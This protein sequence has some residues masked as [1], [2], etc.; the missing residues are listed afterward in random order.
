MFTLVALNL[1]L[2][3]VFA[4]GVV[5]YAFVCW[6]VGLGGSLLVCLCLLARLLA[7]LF[8]CLLVCFAR[9]FARLPVCWYAGVRSCAR[10]FTRLLAFF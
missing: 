3:H 7:C 10:V 1:S 9:L 4:V 2:C 6:F 8:A 5:C